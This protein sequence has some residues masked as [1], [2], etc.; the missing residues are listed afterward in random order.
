MYKEKSNQYRITSTLP[1]YR[2]VTIIVLA[3]LMAFYSCGEGGDQN[4]GPAKK[5]VP[6][7]R[8]APAEKTTL[9]SYVDI[10]GTI[11]ANVFTDIA[12]P[13]DGII[14]TL[15]A[16][17][18]QMVERDK[19]IAVIN[20]NDRVTLISN[21]QL[22]V[23]LAEAKVKAVDKNGEEYNVLIKE[24]EEARKNLDYAREMYQTVP[25]ICPMTGLVTQRWLDEG[26]QVAAKEKIITISDMSSLVI[27]AEVNEKYFEAIQKGKRLPV[28]LNAYPNDSLQGVISL[29]YPQ[30]DPVTRSV[31]FDIRIVN[32][33]KKLLPGMMASIKIP[34]SVKED[35]IA[36]PEQ[37]VLTSPDNKNFLF[38]INKDTMVLK[39]IVHTGIS[40]GNRLEIVE[41]LEE[42]DV[43]V[44]E[45][46]EMLKDNMKVKVTK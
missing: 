26:S 12:S 22:Q 38:V 34:V 5:K 13:A 11:Q 28:V 18:N 10:T 17:E 15:L 45:G 24:L 25:V 21:N 2:I 7:V 42:N 3:V 36:I 4:T 44:V 20:P 41:G 19:I 29:V 9:V 1:A 6:L 32:F 27:K 31:K 40:S 8:A 39:R 37:S 33:N 46:Q 43:V 16:R 14:E 23:E 35:A 30:V